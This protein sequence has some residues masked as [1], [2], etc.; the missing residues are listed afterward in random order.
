MTDEQVITALTDFT[1]KQ[2]WTWKKR[3]ELLQSH[4]IE[5]VDE[6]QK[7]YIKAK[8]NLYLKYGC[9]FKLKSK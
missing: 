1:E 6:I 2:Y 9:T 7:A 5:I 8:L 3:I 4:N